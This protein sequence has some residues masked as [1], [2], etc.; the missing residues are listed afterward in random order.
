MKEKNYVRASGF[1][2]K[3]TK[4][5][6][7]GVLLVLLLLLVLFD[8]FVSLGLSFD[9]IRVPKTMPKNRIKPT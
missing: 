7:V 3:G 5:F 2:D 6:I 1:E 8:K 9:F 4:P